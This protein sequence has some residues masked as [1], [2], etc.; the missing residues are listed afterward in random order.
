MVVATGNIAEKVSCLDPQRQWYTVMRSLYSDWD[1]SRVASTSWTTLSSSWEIRIRPACSAPQALILPPSSS[2]NRT[3]ISTI[4]FLLGTVVLLLLLL[5]VGLPG[6]YSYVHLQAECVKLRLP[7]I[8]NKFLQPISVSS[9]EFFS[10]V[11]ITIWAT[12]EAPEVVRCGTSL[13]E[14]A[15]LFNS[16]RLMVCPGLDPNANNLV[17]STTF[18]SDSTRAM[19]CLVRIETDQADRTQLRMTVA[20]GDPTLTFE[21]KEFIKEQLSQYPYSSHG[22]STTSSSPTS[23]NLSTSTSIRPRALL[24]GL[25]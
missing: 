11:E 7:A 15:D 17:A 4:Q 14:M 13:S 2:E 18:Y 24:A 10:A 23:A 21:L 20:S 22:C 6:T 8:L 9:E 5:G 3:V 19:L 16:L 25:L 1:K 12:T